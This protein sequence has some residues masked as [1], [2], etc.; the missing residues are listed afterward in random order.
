MHS[1]AYQCIIKNLRQ[2]IDASGLK[3][4]V[5]AERSGRTDKQLSNILCCRQRL[6]VEDIP[7]LCEVLNTTPN[8]LYFGQ[9]N[10]KTA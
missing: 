10:S 1:E 9:D 6:A 2:A 4:R 7:I 8:N 3:Q 5:I